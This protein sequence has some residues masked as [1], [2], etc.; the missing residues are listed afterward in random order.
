MKALK[1]IKIGGR[2]IDDPK[3]LDQVITAFSK[4]QSPKIMVHGGGNDATEYSKKFGIEP[5]IVDGR[6]ITDAESLKI[7]QMVYAGLINKNIVARL[8]ALNCAAI[9][10]SGADGNSIAAKKR[11]VKHIDYGF[12]GDVVQV[13]TSV[14]N[15][16]LQCGLTPVFCA[17][18]HDRKGQ[19][20]NTNADTIATELSIAF[21]REYV[22]DLIFCFEQYGVLSE[23]GNENSVISNL[24]LLTYRRLKKA[25]KITEGMIPKLDNAFRA[26]TAGVKNIYITHF[27]AIN[28]LEIKSKSKATQIS[29]N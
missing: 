19:I 13:N 12:V 28:G 27:D 5:K 18:T 15:K 11:A 6:R 1:I 21:S 20:L 3:K 25:G 8:Q 7:V 4:L 17:L 10:L 24:S 26:L 9:G 16:I 29:A 2:I 22:V 23:P 14:L